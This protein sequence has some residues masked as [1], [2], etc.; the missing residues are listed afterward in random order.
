MARAAV[1]PSLSRPRSV[2]LP[3]ASTRIA[4]L[5]DEPSMLDVPTTVPA[6]FTPSASL[7][8]IQDDPSVPIGVAVPSWTTNP[9]QAASGDGLANVVPARYCPFGE[10]WG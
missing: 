3:V 4:W 5:D 8:D 6:S 10:A 9:A 1:Y 7:N 2:N